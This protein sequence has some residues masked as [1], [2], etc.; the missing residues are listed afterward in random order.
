MKSQKKENIEFEL[1]I[2]DEITKQDI[3]TLASLKNIKFKD[4]EFAKEHIKVNKK[5]V[6]TIYEVEINDSDGLIH[7]LVFEIKAYSK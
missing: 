6:K 7:H 4:K 2:E 3:I 1:C 5:D